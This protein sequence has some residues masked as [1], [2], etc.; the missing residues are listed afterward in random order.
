MAKPHHT[1]VRRVIQATFFSIA[2]LRAAWL[3]EASFRQKCVAAVVLL[4]AAFWLGGSA[5]ERALLAGSCLLVLIVELLNSA[6][7]AAVDR[8]S[9]EKHALAARAKDLG[10][11]AVMLSLVLLALTWGLIVWDRFL[12]AGHAAP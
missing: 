8:V 4:P 3:H 7:E 2:G 5:V 9:T 11:A 10:S 1:G 12:T 6:I